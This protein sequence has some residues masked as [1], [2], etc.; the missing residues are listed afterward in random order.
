M[1][2]VHLIRGHGGVALGWRSELNDFVSPI[3][4]IATSRI[5][6]IKF[7]VSQYTLYIISVYLPSRSGGTDVFLRNLLTS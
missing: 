4:S 1:Y 3:T 5:I 7:S 6:G 2:H